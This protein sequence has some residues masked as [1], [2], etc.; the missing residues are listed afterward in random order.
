M[1]DHTHDGH[2]HVDSQ[3]VHIEEAEEPQDGQGETAGRPP[4]HWNKWG[5]SFS[6]GVTLMKFVEC[7]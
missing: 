3:G 7:G 5:P 6:T 2:A 1:V 4:W